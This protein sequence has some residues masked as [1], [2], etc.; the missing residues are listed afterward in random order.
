MSD[1]DIDWDE[2]RKV[3]LNMAELVWS[4]HQALLASGFDENQ[5]IALVL[6]YQK[7]L[8]ST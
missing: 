8:M 4:Y 5:A 2:L 6:E 1:S 7:F 3:V